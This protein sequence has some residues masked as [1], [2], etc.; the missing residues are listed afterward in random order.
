MSEQT[1]G[2]SNNTT[3]AK[4]DNNQAI[5]LSTPSRKVGDNANANSCLSG[6][7]NPK[8]L[9]RTKIIEENTR[10]TYAISDQHGYKKHGSPEAVKTAGTNPSQGGFE[11]NESA[12]YERPIFSIIRHYQTKWQLE[13]ARKEALE[14]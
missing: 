6:P 14:G 3:P 11:V 12:K 10:D 9:R 8:T 5:N 2:S 4:S 7:N 13:L 1:K